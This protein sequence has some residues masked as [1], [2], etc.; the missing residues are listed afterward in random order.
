MNVIE[1]TRKARKQYTKEERE[2][3]KNEERGGKS[4]RKPLNSIHGGV[5][6][7]GRRKESRKN[8]L[9]ATRHHLE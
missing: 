8:E 1:T 9:L 3:R 6:K 4:K 5:V 2:G 7:N